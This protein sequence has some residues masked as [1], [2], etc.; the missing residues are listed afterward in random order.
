MPKTHR[1][2]LVSDGAYGRLLPG[3]RV[4]AIA[5]TDAARVVAE[6][7]S[8]RAGAAL[9]WL[10]AG[11]ENEAAPRFVQ[12][13]RQPSPL[14]PRGGSATVAAIEAA[15]VAAGHSLADVRA[16]VEAGKRSGSLSVTGTATP[17]VNR[18]N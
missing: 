18:R 4:A 3:A 7:A 2:G 10:A 1:S 6:A 16:A 12:G 15:G 11:A 13:E 8:R 14:L 5:A 17:T 9:A